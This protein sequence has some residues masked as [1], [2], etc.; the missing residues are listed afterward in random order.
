MFLQRGS[1]WYRMRKKRDLQ[2]RRRPRFQCSRLH[3]HRQ[4]VED[5][6]L[7]VTEPVSPDQQLTRTAKRWPKPQ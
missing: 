5:F 3:T 6:S 1:Y 4:P 7:A 2:I